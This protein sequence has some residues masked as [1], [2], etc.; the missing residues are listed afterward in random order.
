[1]LVPKKHVPFITLSTIHR[2]K[3]LEAK[4]VAILFP[5]VEH[6]K[7]STQEQIEQ[8]KNLHFVAESRTSH[9]LTWVVQE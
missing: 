2:A 5:P 8:E 9:S 7:A 1:M 6:P 4:H 3:G